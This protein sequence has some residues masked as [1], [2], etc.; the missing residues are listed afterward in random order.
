[1]KIKNLKFAYLICPQNYT[2]TVSRAK[3]DIGTFTVLSRLTG[4]CEGRYYCTETGFRDTNGKFW[5]AT[6]FDIRNFPDDTIEEAVK[7]IKASA[8]ACIKE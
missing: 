4:W 3:C 8:N 6:S 5:L 1:M 2:D 7:R